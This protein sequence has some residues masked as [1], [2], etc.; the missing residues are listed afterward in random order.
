MKKFKIWLLKKLLN[1]GDRI[2]SGSGMHIGPFMVITAPSN[3]EDY[4][5]D[6]D[7]AVYCDGYIV[8]CYGDSKIIEP[9]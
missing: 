4:C 1:P 7:T 8:F 2:D 9:Y 6:A 3:Y 5:H